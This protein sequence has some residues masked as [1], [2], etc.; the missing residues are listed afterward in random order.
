MTRREI[1]KEVLEGGKPPYVPWSFKFTKE[2]F[3][4]ICR[5][6]NVD[7]PD[8]VLHNHLLNLGNDIGV[9]TEITDDLH[10]D[11]FGVVWDRTIDKDI[12]VP[13]EILLPAP[14][15]SFYSFPDP[16]DHRFFENVSENIEEKP[17][18][19]RVFQIGFS[20]F[21]RAWSLR[22]MQNLLQDFLIHPEFG[23]ELFRTIADFNI[24][25]V[26]KAVQYDIDAIYFGDD[27]GQQQGLIMGYDIWKE[28]IYP[29][30]RRMYREVKNAGTYVMIH[31]CGD[32]DEL[33]DDLIHAGIDCFNPFQPEVMDV[34]SLLDQYRGKL[35]F[36]GGL[37]IQKTLPYGSR[38]EVE[39]ESAALLELG[40]EGSYIFSPSHAVEGDISLDN[41]L[42][43]I[44]MAHNQPGFRK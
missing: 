23:H 10:K 9:F 36:H 41:I 19:F 24:Q 22:G 35:T 6:F 26:K 27:W 37:S 20:L 43:F 8:T 42:T 21:E 18:M 33:F 31:C 38:S 16:E 13:L 32:V 3:E 34:R 12:G 44:E 1:I 25:Q 40:S 5:H 17:D 30:I 7:D 11:I 14:D 28:F 2:P 39:K 29:E 15:L 4:A